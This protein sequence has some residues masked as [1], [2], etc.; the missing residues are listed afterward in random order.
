M[1]I[2]AGAIAYRLSDAVKKL[3]W[4]GNITCERVRDKAP[5][6]RKYIDIVNVH[7]K[8]NR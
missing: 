5:M 8:V 1:K 3:G 7:M 4:E 6:E 2:A